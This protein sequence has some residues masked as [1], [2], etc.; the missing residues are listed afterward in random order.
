[1]FRYLRI[2][3]EL[4]LKGSYC[5]SVQTPLR[6]SHFSSFFYSAGLCYFWA[7]NLPYNMAK[8]RELSREA[9]DRLRQQVRHRFLR[10]HSHGNGFRPSS[11]KGA[12]EDL[13]L[14]IIRNEPASESAVSLTRLRKLFYYADPE[15]CPPEQLEKAS[16]GRDFIEA[17]E[18]YVR[19]EAPA[20]PRLAPPL[21]GAVKWRFIWILLLLLPFGGVAAWYFKPK[22]ARNWRE[23][24]NNTSVDSLRSHGFE[25]IDFDPQW[26]SKQL[27]DSTL[28]LYTL[29]GD[30][31]YDTPDTPMITNVLLKKIKCR[32]CKITMK[33]GG[34]NPVQDYQQAGIILLDAAKTRN[35]NIRFTLAACSTCKPPRQ[36]LQMVKNVRGDVI[37]KLQHVGEI[38]PNSSLGNQSLWL[39]MEYKDGLVRFFYHW[40]AEYSSFAEIASMEI[41]FVPAYVGLV[42][43]RGLKDGN[44]NFNNSQAIPVFIDYLKAE[45]GDE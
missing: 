16:F 3:A 29:R 36:G 27:R 2:Y 24:F 42:A 45:S 23:D 17:L 20:T 10:G 12:Y 21:P 15:V 30:Y 26:W 33:L 28:T 5:F 6:S 32:S 18:Q 40:G 1:M 31:W 44:R 39:R 7:T 41:D 43:F 11:F 8:I 25:W 19:E 35:D 34:F 13:R 38:T 14:D 37:E 9:A 4:Y 22:Q